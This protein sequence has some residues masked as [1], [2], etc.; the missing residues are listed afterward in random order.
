MAAEC[1]AIHILEDC[2]FKASYLCKTNTLVSD[3]E[4]C[5]IFKA[6]V[7]PVDC[8]KTFG[9]F[10]MECNDIPSDVKAKYSNIVDVG[11]QASQLNKPINVQLH[12]PIKF[13]LHAFSN[14]TDLIRVFYCIKTPVGVGAIILRDATT[15][16]MDAASRPNDHYPTPLGNNVKPMRMMVHL[17]KLE[18]LDRNKSI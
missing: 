2:K 15:I 18:N 12:L 6:I 4:R 14:V 13:G 10:I 17:L 5:C 1:L 9:D 7:S 3:I 8:D 16:M 11:I